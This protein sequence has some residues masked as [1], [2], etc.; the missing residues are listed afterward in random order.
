MDSWIH[1]KM[2]WGHKRLEIYKTTCKNIY[3]NAHFKDKAM[4]LEYS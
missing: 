4:K 2:F 3:G 1:C